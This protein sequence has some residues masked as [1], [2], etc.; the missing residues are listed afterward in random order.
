MGAVS[1]QRM[2]LGQQHPTEGAAISYGAEIRPAFGRGASVCFTVTAKLQ[3]LHTKSYWRQ[4]SCPGALR[5]CRSFSWVQKHLRVP[6]AE[7]QGLGGSAEPHRYSHS[8]RD[9][10][11]KVP[12]PRLC[13][14]RSEKGE[15]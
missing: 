9:P 6:G 8:S 12:Q 11:G 10:R 3:T 15:S 4:K 2:R 13:S 7:L 1:E 14:E 5:P